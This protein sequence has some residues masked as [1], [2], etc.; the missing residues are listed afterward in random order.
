[1]VVRKDVDENPDVFLYHDSFIPAD[2]RFIIKTEKPEPSN[3]PL[4]VSGE[5]YDI[6]T[7]R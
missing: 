3:T 7:E 4:C 1:L 2:A 6:E 5:L